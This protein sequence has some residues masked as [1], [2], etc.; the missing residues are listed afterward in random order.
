MMH[1][2]FLHTTHFDLYYH[3]QKARKTLNQ[4]IDYFW[5]TDFEDVY[6][7]YPGGFSDA[8]FPNIGYTY[9]V[10]LGTPFVM[11]LGETSFEIRSDGF[12]PRHEYMICHHSKGNRI[13]GIKFK[14]SPV[15]FQKKINFSEY[16]EYIYPLAYL[17][18]RKMIEALKKAR[19]FSERV[20]LISEYYEQIITEHSGSMKQADIVIEILNDCLQENY[21][22]E[23]I[24]N[25]ALKY[26]ISTRTLQRY[27]E[28]TTSISSKHALQI[29]RIRKAIEALTAE[30]GKINIHH[31]GYYD[32]SH[33]LK[34]LRTFVCGH[35]NG[36]VLYRNLIARLSNEVPPQKSFKAKS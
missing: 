20:S 5:E 36:E 23:P 17:L 18:E 27:F 2:E 32:Q 15:I 22:S 1:L 14:V 35:R 24:E 34:H 4:F 25:L 11:Q 26:N 33:F 28:A 16:R 6:R 29:M 8:L 30:K 10:N 21:F 31:Y 7:Q 3:R 13:F 9:L 12:L 19:D